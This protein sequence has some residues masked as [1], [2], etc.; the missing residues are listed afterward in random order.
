MSSVAALRFVVRVL[1]YTS[2]LIACVFM[3]L[4]AWLQ[5]KF[6]QVVNNAYP[7]RF[8]L[9]LILHFAPMFDFGHKKETFQSKESFTR[10]HMHMGAKRPSYS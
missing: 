7:G 4:F 6:Q 10:T 5:V 2:F 1:L 3:R 8:S 9:P